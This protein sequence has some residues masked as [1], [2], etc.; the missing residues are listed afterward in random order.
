MTRPDD[1][2][3]NGRRA[4]PREG[5]RR[6][7]RRYAQR[8]PSD[9]SFWQSLGVLG[10]GGWPIVLA[11]V[12]GALIGR[13]LHAQWDTGSWLTAVLVGVGAAGGM[14]VAWQLIQPRRR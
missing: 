1:I 14:T 6:D 2:S 3:T 5:L 8:D 7:L 4:D 13:W 12:G 9:R 10:A 11:S